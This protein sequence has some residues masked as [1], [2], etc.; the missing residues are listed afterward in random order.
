MH[1]I[2]LPKYII[3]RPDPEVLDVT[4]NGVDNVLVSGVDM[5]WLIGGAGSDVMVGGAGNDLAVGEA[6]N[7]FEWRNA[8]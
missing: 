2:F 7:D 8:A 1:S 5:D 6:R 3:A 4:S